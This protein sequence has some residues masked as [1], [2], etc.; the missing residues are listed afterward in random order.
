MAERVLVVGAGSGIGRALA[1]QLAR[2]GADLVLAGRDRDELERSAADLRL[3]FGQRVEV[4]PFEARDF[5][6]HE[7]LVARAWSRLGDG[8]DGAVVA[9][10][11]MADQAEAEHDI[12]VVI[13]MIDVNFTSYVCLLEALAARMEAAKHGWLCVFSSVAGVRGRRVNYL[14]GATKG[15]LDTYLEGL[16][17]RLARS[18]VQVTC[19]KPG[20]VDTGMTYGVVDPRR[21][22]QAERVASDVLRALR[23][24]RAV[25]YTP[26]PWRFIMLVIR[27][28]P[29]SVFRR[30]AF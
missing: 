18:G 16:D 19:V 26:W 13:E 21:L 8:L 12:G 30:L 15:G 22:A 23:R 10:G 3:R 25:V 27:A 2:A 6:S 14:Y 7:A 29:L 17:A 9:H 4:E 28:L 5:A 24:G 11:A 1:A 20:P